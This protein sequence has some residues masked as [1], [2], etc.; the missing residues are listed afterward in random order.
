MTQRIADAAVLG[1]FSLL[2]NGAVK[3]LRFRRQS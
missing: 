3:L 2:Y 1:L